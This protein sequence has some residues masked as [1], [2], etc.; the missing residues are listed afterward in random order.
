MGSLGVSLAVQG[1]GEY[2]ALARRLRGAANG[3]L[4]KEL[5]QQISEPGRVVVQDVKDAARSMRITSTRG[6]RPNKIRRHHNKAMA[7][8]RGAK[9][10]VRAG[11]RNTHLRETIARATKLQITAKGIRI[12]VDSSQFPESQRHLPRYLDRDKGWRHPLFGNKERWF[13]Q[14]GSPY[15]ASTIG[16][17]APKFREAILKAMETIRTKIEGGS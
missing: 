6:S 9:A 14:H 7:L 2:R 16:K 8:E 12:R 5:R 1:A 4:R 11:G 3:D 10:V 15:F 17:R 13:E